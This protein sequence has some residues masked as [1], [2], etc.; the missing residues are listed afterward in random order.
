MPL[1]MW[2]GYGGAEPANA[3]LFKAQYGYMPSCNVCHR[4]G[5]GSPLNTFGQSFQDHKANAAAFLAIANNDADGDGFANAAE[6][7]AKADPSDAASTP[8]KP[9][10][11]LDLSKLIPR[12]VQAAF[13]EARL[14]KPIDAILTKTEIEKAAAWGVSLSADDENTIYVPVSERKPIGTAVIVRGEWLEDAY[15]LLVTTDRKLAIQQVVPIAGSML[16]KKA[17][18]FYE[19]FAAKTASAFERVQ[20]SQLEQHIAVTVH[21]AVALIDARL[22]K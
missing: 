9:G 21:K 22:K 20:G 8:E 10:D 17:D 1:L 11:W 18:S 6:I 14:Y 16:P 7:A 3:R 13:P 15:F 5:G 12:D 4:D 19:R 2:A